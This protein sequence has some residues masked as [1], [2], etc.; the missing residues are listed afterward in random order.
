[1]WL[2]QIDDIEK[3]TIGVMG[4]DKTKESLDIGYRLFPLIDSISITLFN[5]GGKKYLKE[6]GISHPYLVYTMFRNGILHKMSNY[7]LVYDDGEIGWA[8]FSSS[9]TGGF[10]PYDEGYVSTEYPETNMPAEV[11]FEYKQLGN[12]ECRAWLF[13]DRLAAQIRHDLK[14]RKL[15]D[16]RTHLSIVTGKR[17][18]GK[19]PSI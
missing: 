9:G 4:E 6:L 3:S 19:K 14:K 7:R 15:A 2:Q 12:G 17:I 8:T 5:S 18:H 16:K 10:I 1:M 13:L 11:V